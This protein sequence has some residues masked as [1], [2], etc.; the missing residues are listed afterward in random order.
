[1]CTHIEGYLALALDIVKYIIQ[2]RKQLHIF[3][4]N[5]GLCKPKIL[6][7]YEGNLQSSRKLFADLDG[8]EHQWVCLVQKRIHMPRAPLRL[9][10]EYQAH[11][12]LYNLVSCYRR[13]LQN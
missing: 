10:L 7:Y 8:L 2:R 3:I 12:G 9:L 1:M 6:D 5:S 13:Q 11:Q 4:S